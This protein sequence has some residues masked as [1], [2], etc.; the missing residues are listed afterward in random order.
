MKR[1]FSFFPFL[2]VFLLLTFFSCKPLNMDIRGYRQYNSIEDIEENYLLNLGSI[3]SLSIPRVSFSFTENGVV[4]YL[5][6]SIRAIID[7]AILI[8]VQGGFG[9]EIVRAL[10][11]YGSIQYIDRVNSEYQRFGFDQF[12]YMAGV[13]FEYQILENILF[14]NFRLS[15]L[16]TRKDYKIVNTSEHI[17]IHERDN[18]FIKG[19]EDIKVFFQRNN[20]LISKIEFIDRE[21]ILCMSVDYANFRTADTGIAIPHEVK[22][23][24]RNKEEHFEVNLKY[25]RIDLNN[26][27]NISFIVPSKYIL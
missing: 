2:F 22:I 19:F 7:S 13:A 23:S 26:F 8:S 24:L 3:T 5:N 6:G 25:N 16:L 27:S 14:N 4:T 12:K 1:S 18:N 9:I 20:F 21:R 15:D 17:V 11:T 10:V